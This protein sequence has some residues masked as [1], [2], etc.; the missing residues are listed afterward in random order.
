MAMAKPKPRYTCGSLRFPSEKHENQGPPSTA[1][2]TNENKSHLT[3]AFARVQHGHLLA[4]LLIVSLIFCAS[5]LLRFWASALLRFCASALLRFCASALLR[6][7]DSALL[8]LRVSALLR[9]C[10]SA[11]LR[12]CASALLRFW[13]S[14][15]LR[16][17]ASALLRFCDSALL[18]FCASALLRFC[19]SALHPGRHSNKSVQWSG[20]DRT[21]QWRNPSR[22]KHV[23]HCNSYARSM[24]TKDRPRPPSE[25][26]KT[27]LIQRVLLRECNKDTYWH[28]Y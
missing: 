1:L 25:P 2:R 28:R 4:P 20:K 6:F 26:M 22:A 3:S 10:A 27:N 14:A 23:D 21:L 12:F 15:L 7:C 9:C 18:R 11:L 19:A 13:A 24:K 5:A 17:C 16:F 8:R